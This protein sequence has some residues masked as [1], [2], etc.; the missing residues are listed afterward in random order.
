MTQC[1]VSEQLLYVTRNC[2]T[3]QTQRQNLVENLL[4]NKDQL[5][6][7]DSKYGGTHFCVATKFILCHA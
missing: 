7:K 2:D 5:I 1:K 6:L 4:D 3:M